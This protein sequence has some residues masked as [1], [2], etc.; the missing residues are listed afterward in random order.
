M[1]KKWCR[2]TSLSPWKILITSSS[3]REIYGSEEIT[4]L[5][6]VGVK[7]QTKVLKVDFMISD[8]PPKVTIQE[9]RKRR[10]H[11]TIISSEK[12]WAKWSNVELPNFQC[13][14][15]WKIISNAFLSWKSYPMHSY[16]KN[17]FSC[18]LIVKII[19][20]AFL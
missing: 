16:S 17:H 9:L 3:T 13:I 19:S 1:K 12:I 7:Y 11:M 5:V 6:S 15:D 8:G 10:K 2:P 20:S 14:F 18:I 4:A